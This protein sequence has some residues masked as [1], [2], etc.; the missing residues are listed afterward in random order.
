MIM[1]NIYSKTAV[2]LALVGG[3]LY[4]A[5]YNSWLF[6]DGTDL[7][8]ASYFAGI[9]SLFSS[10]TYPEQSLQVAGFSLTEDISIKIAIAAAFLLATL[11]IVLS[12]WAIVQQ[13]NSMLFSLAMLLGIGVFTLFNFQLALG[14]LLVSASSGLYIRNRL[15]LG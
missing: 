3:I 9:L 12:L 8:L 4:L 6:N 10:T 13:E 14:L 11:A 2:L 15:M 5:A 1:R 7:T